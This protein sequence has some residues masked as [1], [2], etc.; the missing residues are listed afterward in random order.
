M[1]GTM[2]SP[3]MYIGLLQSKLDGVGTIEGKK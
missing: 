1:F 3:H 2:F